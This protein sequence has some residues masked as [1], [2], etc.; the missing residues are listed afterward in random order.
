MIISKK[1]RCLKLIKIIILGNEYNRRM[2][3]R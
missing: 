2:Y 3:L 1:R